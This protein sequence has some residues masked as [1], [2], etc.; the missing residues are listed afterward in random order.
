MRAVLV[1]DKPSKH[2]TH[3]DIPF[4]GT[5]SWTRLQGWIKEMKLDHVILRNQCDL[6]PGDIMLQEGPVVA[7]GQAAAKKLTEINILH[8][9]LPHPSGLNRQLN[10]KKRLTRKLARARLW[11]EERQEK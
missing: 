11:I 4:K 2:N 7:L 10:D 9:T 5:A 6:N 8:F 3:P 1:G